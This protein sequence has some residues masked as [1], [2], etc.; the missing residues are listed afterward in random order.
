MSHNPNA[1]SRPPLTRPRWSRVNFTSALR[2]A[3][4]RCACV[5]AAA[6]VSLLG[7]TGVGFAQEQP[8]PSENDLA[9]LAAQIL[10]DGVSG[11]PHGTS[12]FENSLENREP[13]A[14]FRDA[15]RAHLMACARARW[16]ALIGKPPSADEQADMEELVDQ[17]LASRALIPLEAGGDPDGFEI[18]AGSGWVEFSRDM[19]L[20]AKEGWTDTSAR[21]RALYTD[22]EMIHVL[23]TE[24]RDNG[25]HQTNIDAKRHP[26]SARDFLMTAPSPYWHVARVLPKAVA[27]SLEA[28]GGQWK[29]RRRDGRISAKWEAVSPDG[30]WPSR[31][32]SALGSELGSR[33]LSVRSMN[34]M[35][36][37]MSCVIWSSA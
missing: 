33:S 17:Q 32:R 16:D 36:A 2:G 8:E 37:P 25:V 1:W 20:E 26:R 35:W 23:N 18:S 7:M 21:L 12:V 4:A 30:P 27:E 15:A 31:T 14:G 10:R 19:K 5:V 34:R 13:P 28:H 6:A 3:P 11:F 24:W 9:L 29:C 22:R